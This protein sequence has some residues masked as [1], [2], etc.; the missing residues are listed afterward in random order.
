LDWHQE[1]F[2]SVAQVSD[3]AVVRVRDVCGVKIFKRGGIDKFAFSS[4]PRHNSTSKVD[5]IND[6]EPRRRGGIVDE[7]PLGIDA[8]VPLLRRKLPP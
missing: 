8:I 3:G 6:A 2:C 5:L 7:G 1:P 4:K